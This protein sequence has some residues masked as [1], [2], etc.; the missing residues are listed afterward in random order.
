MIKNIMEK[1]KNV[2]VNFKVK[3]NNRQISKLI[4]KL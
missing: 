3:I 2:Y 1:N 4:K